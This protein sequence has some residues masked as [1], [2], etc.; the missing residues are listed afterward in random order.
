VRSAAAEVWERK[1]GLSAA[2]VADLVLKEL[3]DEAGLRVSAIRQ[4]IADLSPERAK[5][6]PE[7]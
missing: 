2:K 1:P 7:K 3:G 6:C 5:S 4:A